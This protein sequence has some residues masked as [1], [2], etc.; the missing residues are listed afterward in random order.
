MGLQDAVDYAG[1]LLSPET[2][3]RRVDHNVSRVYRDDVLNV[4]G[5][6]RGL[7]LK[8]QLS[9][10][11]DEHD[12]PYDSLH[13]MLPDDALIRFVLLK[14]LRVISSYPQNELQFVFHYYF[15]G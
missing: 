12:V 7:R 10:Y 15:D 6:K 1:W 14:S 5:G 2:F 11:Y 13:M 8:Q 3:P 9:A 4:F